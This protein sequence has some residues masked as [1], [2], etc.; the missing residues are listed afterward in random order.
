FPRPLSQRDAAY[1]LQ[2][3]FGESVPRLQPGVWGS[4]HEFAARLRADCIQANG[5]YPAALPSLPTSTSSAAATDLHQRIV[6]VRPL[7]LPSW[8]ASLSDKGFLRPYASPN[9]PPG[10]APSA[11]ERRDPHRRSP[12]EPRLDI[13]R[14]ASSTVCCR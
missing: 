9:T 1:G 8:R 12:T 14:S 10:Q 3:T 11:F 2:H 7:S 13:P 5:G 4:S 6:A